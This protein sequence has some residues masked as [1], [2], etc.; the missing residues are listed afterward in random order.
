MKYLVI[1][2]ISVA[3]IYAEMGCIICHTTEDITPVTQKKWNFGIYIDEDKFMSSTHKDLQC[4]EC[5]IGLDDQTTTN[6]PH[7]LLN[8]E[9]LSCLNCHSNFKDQ[10][11]AFHNSFHFKKIGDNFTCTECHNPHEMISSKNS[12]METIAKI[13]RDNGVCLD[14]HTDKEKF[15]KF[16]RAAMPI[17]SE[18]H[19]FIP[20]FDLHAKYARCVE[21]HT[22]VNDKTSHNIMDRI[23]ARKD[24][25]SCHSDE[26]ILTAKL[27]TDNSTDDKGFQN[28]GLLKNSYVLGATR[29][30]YLDYMFGVLLILTI[31]G[32]FMHGFLRFITKKAKPNLVEHKSYLYTLN[33]RIWHWTN[34]TLF[35]LLI[36]SGIA[37]RF[38]VLIPFKDAV[39][40]HNYSGMLLTI[41]YTAF[42]IMNIA[43]G[44]LRN[45]IP[46][47]KGFFTRIIKQAR[48]YLF[49]IFKG[50]PH[51][52]HTTKE[53]KFNPLQQI[54]YFKFMYGVMPVL[55][56]TGI[57]M[58]EPSNA[59]ETVLG[60]GGIWLISTIHYI[61]AG[62]FVLFMFGHM[63]L[64]T[65][66]DKPLYLLKGMFTGFHYSLEDKEKDNSTH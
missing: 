64:A 27:Y 58:L 13:K 52:Y 61:S 31:G 17:I 43:D 16:T 46:K 32:T 38:S 63:Y 25:N 48:F 56:I 29:N 55:V 23:S 10:E 14:C 6:L 62:I 57:M 35:V 42:F 18:T 22:D 45:Y 2:L 33:I 40:M 47:P 12:K 26:S 3:T 7:D 54:T 19:S 9:V 28:S 4:S 41:A 24:C 44:N 66:G 20:N 50:E 60:Y 37:I 5:H 51:P 8:Y 53:N 36:I 1:V 65:T 15:A 59:P 34:A 21:C 49:G 30:I 39:K 11:D